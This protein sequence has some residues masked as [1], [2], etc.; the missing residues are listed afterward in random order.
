M[1]L[2]QS[3]KNEEESIETGEARQRFPGLSAY[4]ISVALSLAQS[5]LSKEEIVCK[6]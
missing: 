3:A 2:D 4:Q 6:R 5:S 1:F